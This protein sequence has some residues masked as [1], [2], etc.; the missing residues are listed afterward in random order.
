MRSTTVVSISDR[1]KPNI[2]SDDEILT[3]DETAAFLKVTKR[4]LYDQVQ[5][6]A[7]PHLRVGKLIRFSKVGLLD[8]MKEQAE[9]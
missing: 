4:M 7:I 8:W 6:R 1:Q 5:R 9:S 2:E 3:L